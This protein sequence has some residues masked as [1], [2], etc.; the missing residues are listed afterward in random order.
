MPC[1]KTILN[2]SNKDLQ[3]PFVKM[4]YTFIYIVYEVLVIIDV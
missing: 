2:S 1:Q 3:S 4:L